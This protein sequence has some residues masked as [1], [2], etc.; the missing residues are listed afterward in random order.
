MRFFICISVVF[1]SVKVIEI[2]SLILLCVF[3]M[4]CILK[5]NKEIIDGHFM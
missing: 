1:M 3:C 5:E 4:C 2:L